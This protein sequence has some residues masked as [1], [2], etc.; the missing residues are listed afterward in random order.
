MARV[1]MVTL[2]GTQCLI[3]S[4]PRVRKPSPCYYTIMGTII[5]CGAQLMTQGPTV[6]AVQKLVATQ[7]TAT[8]L[9]MA[10]PRETK[11]NLQ[12]GME[13]GQEKGW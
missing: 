6:M 11:K 7:L 3:P 12:A 9:S 2:P 4:Y 5:G 1:A 13:A 10:T 8:A